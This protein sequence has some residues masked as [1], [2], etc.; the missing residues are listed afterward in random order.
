MTLAVA[1]LTAPDGVLLAADTCRVTMGTPAS[2]VDDSR[3]LV[4]DEERGVAAAQ[5]GNAYLGIEP[6]A[7]VIQRCLDAMP[8]QRMDLWEATYALA[9]LL[10]EAY[11]RQTGGEGR[12]EVLL[13]GMHQDWPSHSRISVEKIAVHITC[14]RPENTPAS[15]WIGATELLGAFF[16]GAKLGVHRWSPDKA[17][18]VVQYVARQVGE[19]QRLSEDTVTINEHIQA[20]HITSEELRVLA[21]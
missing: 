12:L 7:D 4:W 13:A 19:I 9:D 17:V 20:V 1:I 5:A 11:W 14:Y 8:R 15:S 10:S 21:R 6:A 3:K 2:H 16:N 18:Q